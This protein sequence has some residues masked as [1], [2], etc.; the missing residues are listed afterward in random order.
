MSARTTTRACRDAGVMAAAIALLLVIG[1]AAA[2]VAGQTVA[3]VGGRA[4][5]VSGPPIENATVLIVDGKITA[6]GANVAVPAGAERVDAKGQWVTPGLIHVSTRL[7]LA[8]IDLVDETVDAI[9][10]GDRDVA[11]GFRSWEGINPESPLWA[12]A[13]NDGITSVVPLPGGG[14]ISGQAA[15]VDTAGSDRAAMIRRAPVVMVADFGQPAAGGSRARGE[16]LMRLRELLSDARTFSLRRDAFENAGTRTFATGRMHLEALADVLAGKVPILA[17][18]DRASDIDAAL[19]LAAE[20][21]LRIIVHGG[22]EAWKVAG[23]LAKAGVP[24][25][26]GALGNVPSSFSTLGVRQENAAILSQA[27][28]RVILIS[29]PGD[30]FRARTIRQHAGNAVAYGLPWD[31]A[32]KAVTL[33]P[34]D[35]LG[36]GDTVG[37]LQPGRDGNVVVWDG[38]PFEFATHATHVFIRGR[39]SRTPSREDLLAERY[40]KK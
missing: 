28:V 12:P 5:P 25:V 39:E 15:L 32:L 11:A 35:V 1:G 27:G 31:E 6:V 34:A 40:R 24:V 33:T 13:R 4:F 36:V 20:F 23:R 29:D 3:I 21:K 16:M 37:S 7:G 2:P 9:A 30:T 10:K 8:E 14:L 26:T 18:V 19:D 38:D 22:A 17:S